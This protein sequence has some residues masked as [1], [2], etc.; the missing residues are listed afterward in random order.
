MGHGLLLIVA[1]LAMRIAGMAIAAA[2]FDMSL[3][4]LQTE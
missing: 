2:M 3:K 4:H 1:G